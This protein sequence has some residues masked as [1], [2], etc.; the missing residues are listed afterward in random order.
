MDTNARNDQEKISLKAV[1][2][3]DTFTK[4]LEPLDHNLSEVLM[5]VGNIPILEYMIDF[6]ISNSIKEII[7]CAKKNNVSIEK[8][9]RKYFSYILFLLLLLLQSFN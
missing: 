2:I 4:L 1:I 6:L 7:I 5:P 9:L 3:A 8:Y